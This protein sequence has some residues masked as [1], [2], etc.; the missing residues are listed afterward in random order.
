MPAQWAEIS[1]DFRDSFVANA[2]N[3]VR[4][5]HKLDAE[6]LTNSGNLRTTNWQKTSGRLPP[7]RRRGQK[8]SRPSRPHDPGWDNSWTRRIGKPSP[9]PRVP[10][11]TTMR[12]PRRNRQ[13]GL[14]RPA[15]SRERQDRPRGHAYRPTPEHTPAEPPFFV[16]SNLWRGPVHATPSP[17]DDPRGRESFGRVP[18][19]LFL[20]CATSPL[21]RAKTQIHLAAKALIDTSEPYPATT[22]KRV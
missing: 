21:Q 17:Q 5:V 1:P 20:P 7:A 16:A 3:T 12:L 2:P 9:L 15:G 14:W 13:H 11:A 10:R 18:V 8:D 19:G 4:K 22:L 6:A